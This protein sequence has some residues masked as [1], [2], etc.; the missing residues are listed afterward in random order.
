MDFVA[1][2]SE[3]P[4]QVVRIGRLS[5]VHWGVGP[6]NDQD[7]HGR[8]LAQGDRMGSFILRDHAHK[9]VTNTSVGSF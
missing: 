8:A 3:M 5:R 6:R 4:T 9:P 2:F 1:S 7:L